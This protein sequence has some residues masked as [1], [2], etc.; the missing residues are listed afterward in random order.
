MH[1]LRMNGYTLEALDQQGYL[2]DSTVQGVAHPFKMGNLWEIPMSI[3]DASLVPS[4]QS[5]LNLKEWQEATLTKLNQAEDMQIPY[6]VINHHD[7]YFD[8]DT[9]P[10]IYDWFHWLIDEIQERKLEVVS[11]GE[12]IQELTHTLI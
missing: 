9:F 3:M 7:I 4:T 5:N 8:K 12:V 2:F 10:T 11:F 1:Y 6:F